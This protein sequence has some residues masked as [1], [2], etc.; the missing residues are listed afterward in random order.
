MAESLPIAF[1]VHAMP[2]R[3]RLRMCERRDDTAFFASVATVLSAMAGVHKVEIQP[4]TGSILVQHAVPLAQ[5]GAMAENAR[6][7]AIETSGAL[8]APTPS[9][10]TKFVLDPKLAAITALAVMALWQGGK[11]KFLPPAMTLVWYAASLAFSKGDFGD[12]D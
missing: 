6:L 9:E 10:P 8:A 7:F 4:L 12:A 11:G 5:I 3:T 2:G 1:V